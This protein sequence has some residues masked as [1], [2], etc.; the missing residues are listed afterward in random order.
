MKKIARCQH[1]QAKFLTS[2]LHMTRP[3][4]TGGIRGKCI[5]CP[6]SKCV[7][8]RKFCFTPTMKTKIS[9][10]KMHLPTK[11]LDATTGLHQW[12]TESGFW[13]PIRPDIGN[14]WIWIGYRFLFNRMRCQA[15]FLTS[16]KFLTCYCYAVYFASQNTEI[17]SCIYFFDVCCVN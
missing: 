16:A 6:P 10:P 13:S 5:F 7:V 8:H 9:P 4:A 2:A 17:K 14:F 3:K 1:S 15:K 11:P 12:C